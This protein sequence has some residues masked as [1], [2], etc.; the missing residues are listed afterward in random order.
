MQDSIRIFKQP[1][2]SRIT[3][4]SRSSIYRLE[5]LGQF[6]ARVKLGEAACGWRSDEIEAWIKS[7][8]RAKVAA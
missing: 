4:L 8:Q 6:P 1:E 7:R 2:A 3:G 5:A